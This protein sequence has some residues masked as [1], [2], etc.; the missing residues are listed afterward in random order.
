MNSSFNECAVVID[1][2]S[3]TYRAYYATWNQMQYFI[4]NNIK[5]NNAIKLMLIMVLKILQDFNPKYT[6]IA[7][8]A[9]K[10]TFRHEVFKQYKANRLK[11]PIELINQIKELHIAIT[12]CGYHAYMQ[13]GIEADDIIGSF[14]SLM[15]KNKVLCKI[16][17]SDRD[18]LQLV[19][20]QTEVYM[21]KKGVSEMQLFNYYNFEQLMDGLHPNQITDYKGIV[22]DSSD[23][24]PGIKGIGK[25]TGIKLLQKFGSLENIYANLNLLNE[26]QKKLFIN[27]KEIAFQCKLLSTIK[28]DIFD[29]KNLNDFQRPLIKTEKLFDFLHEC[30]INN[31]EK[32]IFSVK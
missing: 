8:D 12:L 2:N 28:K 25:K 6:L 29:N 24:I 21:P 26:K 14:A 27:S 23:N 16:F 22:G 10:K 11:T 13:E 7:F 3:L 32:Y 1:G 30:K 18:M 31:M 5:P 19:N 20:E 9:G 17:S 4:S 15:N